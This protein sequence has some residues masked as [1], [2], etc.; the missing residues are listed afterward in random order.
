MNL[1]GT[2]NKGMHMRQELKGAGALHL[3]RWPLF[4]GGIGV[5]LL[6]VS[7]S[8]GRETYRQWKVDQ[9]IQGLQTQVETLQGKRVHLLDTIQKLSSLDELD[10]EAR[11]HLDVKKSGEQVIVLKGFDTTSIDRS[12]ATSLVNSHELAVVSNPKK[13]L[14]YFF[15]HD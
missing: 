12:N 11:M 9:E 14:L 13:W 10:K 1:Y 2:M 8:A 3:I 4:L 6:V 15:K 7:V 5:L